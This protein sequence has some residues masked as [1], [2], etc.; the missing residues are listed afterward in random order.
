MNIIP[1]KK[2]GKLGC[3]NNMDILIKIKIN[4]EIENNKKFINIIFD[5]SIS[6]IGECFLNLK[7]G[8]KKLIA[9]IPNDYQI[10]IYTNEKNIYCGKNLIIDIFSILNSVKCEGINNYS[11][12]FDL[13]LENCFL[14]TDEEVKNLNSKLDF[15]IIYH[16][17]SNDLKFLN[18]ELNKI[19]NNIGEIKIKFYALNQN[20]IKKIYNYENNN[21]CIIKNFSKKDTYNILINM[22]ILPINEDCQD[23]LEIKLIKNKDIL[24]NNKFRM[25]FVKD[26]NLINNEV[27]VH[28]ILNE[29]KV[30]EKTIKD[31][32]LQ[33]NIQKIKIL[34]YKLKE[35]YDYPDSILL[36]EKYKS[37]LDCILY[38]EEELNSESLKSL[39]LN[40]EMKYNHFLT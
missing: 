33:K 32:Y 36:K 19:L 29:G 14:F 38:I 4:P 12:Y 40:Y 22:D 26:N 34:L 2:Y 27:I 23:V 3:V 17:K 11:K 37:V 35:I 7:E 5:N 18:L 8:I 13:E 20:F 16:E 10:N 25:V 39:E 28:K 6:T 30:L 1:E 21:M 15:K 9:L 24:F 31:L